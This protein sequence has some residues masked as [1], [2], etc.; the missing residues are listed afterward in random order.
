MLQ[1][2]GEHA[3]YKYFELDLLGEGGGY[4]NY[5]DDGTRYEDRPMEV[6]IECPWVIFH[7]QY[8]LS[9]E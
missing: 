2:F 5:Y 8:Q 9:Y 4:C 1:V 6:F 7:F 3:W